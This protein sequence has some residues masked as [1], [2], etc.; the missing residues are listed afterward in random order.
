MHLADA[1][2]ASGSAHQ[3]SPYTVEDALTSWRTSD[4]RRI[5]AK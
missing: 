1:E 5:D 4:N 2:A 3:M